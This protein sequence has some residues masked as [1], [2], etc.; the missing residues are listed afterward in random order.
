MSGR[1]ESR[2]EKIQVKID[3]YA[4]QRNI[5]FGDI[6]KNDGNSGYNSAYNDAYTSAVAGVGGSRRPTQQQNRHYIDLLKTA[7]IHYW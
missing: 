2:C 6:I 1:Y 3:N 5:D 4:A 7:E